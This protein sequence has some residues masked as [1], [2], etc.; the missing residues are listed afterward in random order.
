MHVHGK[1][2]NA[3]FA[4]EGAALAALKNEESLAVTLV[5]VATDGAP[6][7]NISLTVDSIELTSD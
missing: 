2:L 3:A 7:P 4:V 5:P 1:G 6:P